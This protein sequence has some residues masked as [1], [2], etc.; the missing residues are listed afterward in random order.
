MIVEFNDDFRFETM[1]PDKKRIGKIQRSIGPVDNIC[2]ADDEKICKFDHISVP[3]PGI[4]DQDPVE[5]EVETGIQKQMGEQ[6]VKK[7]KC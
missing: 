7:V 6:G 1:R 2:Q 4:W 5:V 3:T